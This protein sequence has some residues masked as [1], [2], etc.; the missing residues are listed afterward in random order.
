[1]KTGSIPKLL[2]E[3]AAIAIGAYVLVFLCHLIVA[4]Y[5]LYTEAESRI[6]HSVNSASAERRVASAEHT[7]LSEIVRELSTTCAVKDGVNRT[8]EKQNRDQQS[9]INGCLSQAIRLLA[10]QS[11]RII[12]Q[13]VKLPADKNGPHIF[14]AVIAHTNLPITPLNVTLKC[15]RDVI[16]MEDPHMI[17]AGIAMGYVVEN[18]GNLVNYRVLSP[19][20]VP[21][22]ALVFFVRT[23]DFQPECTLT[24]N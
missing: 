7:R 3:G 20:W 9:T 24:T 1:M 12:T 2:G 19:P 16:L 13:T 22:E 4:P 21:D 6:K 17:G 15:N 14:S 5:G 10:P 8:L 23:V 11:L 18:K